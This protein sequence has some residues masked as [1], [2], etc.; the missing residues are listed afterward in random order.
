MRTLQ[1]S[2]LSL[3]VGGTGTC[4]P[5]NLSGNNFGGIRNTARVD[6][7][8]V[9]IYEGVVAAASHVIERVANAF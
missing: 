7:D 1:E 2:E 3:V 6:S 4:T 5:E 8:F 9:N